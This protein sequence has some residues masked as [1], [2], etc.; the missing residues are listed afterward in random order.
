[1]IRFH[2]QEFTQLPSI[3]A[4]LGLYSMHEHLYT[5]HVRPIIDN[6]CCVWDPY[7]RKHIKQLESVQRHA[8]P[9]T[10]VNYY[11][12]NPGCVTNMVTQVGWTY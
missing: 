7:Q 9:F 5:S 11:S 6:A 1:M 3:R 2:S 10:T 4:K 12:M 8:A